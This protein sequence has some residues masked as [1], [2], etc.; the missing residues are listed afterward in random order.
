MSINYFQKLNMV[1]HLV[2]CS[3]WTNLF[4][5]NFFN[6]ARRKWQSTSIDS[7]EYSAHKNGDAVCL[8]H[9]QTASM[10]L[11]QKKE[12]GTVTIE[13]ESKRT[14]DK[15][16]SFSR[17]IVGETSPV[18]CDKPQTIDL[19]RFKV[20]VSFFET[21]Q[22]SVKF[23]DSDTIINFPA[24]IVNQKKEL[25]MGRFFHAVS[26]SD[27][28]GRQ[29]EIGHPDFINAFKIIV[30]KEMGIQPT[31]N[32]KNAFNENALMALYQKRIESG[33]PNVL[34]D[35]DYNTLM[36]PW[37]DVTE[38]EGHD[39]ATAYEFCVQKVKDGFQA[40]FSAEHKHRIQS[41][42]SIVVQ[43]LEN[44]LPVSKIPEIITADSLESVVSS[45]TSLCDPHKSQ[46]MTVIFD[47]AV[48]H[49]IWDRLKNNGAAVDDQHAWHVAHNQD[50]SLGG[51]EIVAMNVS[52]DKCVVAMRESALR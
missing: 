39:V 19:A 6:N 9:K 44:A 49:D 13:D 29:W 8:Q 15:H 47:R 11:F 14:Y 32:A 16:A 27:E 48:S 3:S 28:L 24:P 21:G 2:N 10:L 34:R 52:K 51:D 23:H 46:W 42:A 12:D 4:D 20:S 25:P 31:L 36:K 38:F 22:K 17:N 30:A 35:A 33:S 5:I 7:I 26:L 18:R 40:C 43:A 50:R 1:E 41:H 37:R 45:G